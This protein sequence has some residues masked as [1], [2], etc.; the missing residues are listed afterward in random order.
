MLFPV[1]APT[2]VPAIVVLREPENSAL[3]REIL[4]AAAETGRRVGLATSDGVR[5]SARDHLTRARTTCSRSRP[6]PWT[7]A[8]TP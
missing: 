2:R 8:S 1:G 3:D 6:P 5:S 4:A 7:A